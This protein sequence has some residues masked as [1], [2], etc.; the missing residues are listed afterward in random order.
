MIAFVIVVSFFTTMISIPSGIEAA[1][2]RSIGA[3]HS[4]ETGSGAANDPK[5]AMD[6]S[7]NAIVVWQQFDGA[8][9]SIYAN[10][11]TAGA[12][13]TAKLIETGPGDAG[14]PQ[15]A[16][17]KYGDAVA[18]WQQ[19]D[20]AYN[21]I[22]A[23]TFS[24]GGWKG[25][26]VIDTGPGEARSPQ[27]A[28]DDHGNAMAIWV[29]NDSASHPSIYAA[30]FLSG[31]W[32]APNLLETRAGEAFEPQVVI[33][34]EGNAMAIWVQALGMN[35]SVYYNRFITGHWG[36]AKP[37]PDP[38]TD[39]YNHYAVSPQIAVDGFGNVMV[40]WLQY[41]GGLAN[42][43]IV[44]RFTSGSWETPKLI[45]YSDG[46]SYSF[47]SPRLVMNN[48]GDAAVFWENTTWMSTIFLYG[49][50]FVSGVWSAIGYIT[51]ENYLQQFDWQAVIDN[52]GNILVVWSESY[53]DFNKIEPT[54]EDTYYARFHSGL[55][56]SNVKL[57]D[58]VVFELQIAV[59]VD[60]KAT[61]VWGGGDILALQFFPAAQGMVEPLEHGAGF[62]SK[63][64]VAMD[65]NGNALA[66]WQQF[67][68]SHESIYARRCLSGVWGPVTL[69]E[70]G[71]GNAWSPQV[72]MDGHGNAL[73][74]WQQ[75]DSS[76]H[77]SL[78]AK[79]L[80]SGSWGPVTLLEFGSGNAWS[81]QVAMNDHGSAIVVWSQ[82][83]NA[84]HLSIYARHFCSGSW[85]PVT[86][87][88]DGSGNAW[89]PQ[90][91][92]DNSG[93]A[94]V[95]WY[96][97]DSSSHLGVYARH[98]SSGSW[99]AIKS[100][101]TGG[102]DA[103][104]AQVAMD[105]HGNAMVVWSETWWPTDGGQELSGIYADRFSS[106]AW[107][108]PKLLEKNSANN[109]LYDPRIA[110]DSKGDAK[111]VWFWRAGL[112]DRS[113]HGARYEEGAWGAVDILMSVYGGLSSAEIAMD[114]HGNAMVVCQYEGAEDTNVGIIV[115]IMYTDGGWDEVLLEHQAGNTWNPQVT[116]D[117]CGR[118]MV[119]WQQ[120][121]G[122]HGGIYETSRLLTG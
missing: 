109:N 5:I 22:Y 23:N 1:P 29:Q 65:G 80:T 53:T 69:L 31:A 4:L 91:A 6:G 11:Q 44:D 105:G 38:V 24:Q 37:V 72:A 73:V 117:D 93:G 71:S 100:L 18:V 104:D 43:I 28:M 21:S 27:I 47:G 61:A 41:W 78:Y 112:D 36:T 25:A 59:D 110:I 77:L 12:W 118:A 19:F 87:L 107:G 86:L 85:G 55:W 10:R 17:D 111:A 81:P 122:A 76:S 39:P 120:D 79:R 20:G 48:N 90:V 63:P 3:T 46:Y 89:S 16:M 49:V 103:S 121:D 2:S 113:V 66:V 7:G 52:D 102:G 9:C 40:A 84:A 15:I 115:A 51:G 97:L 119:V 62:A 88:E 99:E 114:N 42:G 34:H 57:M 96:Q 13:G 35:S 94:M 50:T 8:H 83:D 95:V 106:G 64:Q 116:A 82:Y 30:G 98:F 70:F 33:D 58:N 54:V 101:K 92:M 32:R 26:K 56:G 68:G 75:F 45:I 60:G 108:E 67:D 74:V 14:S